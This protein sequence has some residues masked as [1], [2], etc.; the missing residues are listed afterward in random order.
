M[1]RYILLIAL[2]LGL[3]GCGKKAERNDTAAGPEK[4]DTETPA[5]RGEAAVGG[6]ATV[7][8]GPKEAIAAQFELLKKGDV[9]GLRTWFTERVRADITAEAVEKGRAE[10]GA[11]TLDDLAAS[12]DVEEMG[13]R[14]TAKVK[15]KNG[16]TLTT[17]ILTDGRWK[18]DT[19][20]FK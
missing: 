1:F 14:K 7:A 5:E 12:I 11:Y 20:W 6:V 17:L 3:C 16:R 15:M 10:A 18:A 2:I 4:A 19:I 8:T 13:G 9:E